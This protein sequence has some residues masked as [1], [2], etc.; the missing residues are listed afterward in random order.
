MLKYIFIATVKCF[1]LSDSDHLQYDGVSQG[2]WFLLFQRNMWP[3]FL[4][5]KVHGPFFRILNS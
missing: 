1:F 4:R 3:S 5:F 2:S